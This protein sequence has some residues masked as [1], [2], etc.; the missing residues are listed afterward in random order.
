MADLWTEDIDGEKWLIN[1][2]LI[3]ANPG[4]RVK[5][6]NKR[7]VKKMASRRKR[8]MPA[9]LRRYWASRRKAKAN[10]HRRRRRVTMANPRRRR[11]AKR[12]F[13]MPGMLVNP[14]RRRSSRRRRRGFLMN[15][16]HRRH[17]RRNPQLLGFQLPPVSDI[18]FV[19]AGLVVPPIVSNYIMT[20]F[21]PSYTTSVPV[22]WA[23]NVASVVGP[24]L[25]VRKFVSQRAGNLMLLG[26]A[27]T[28][29]L[30]AIKT[31]MP[32][33]IPGLSGM[34]YQPFLGS[35]VRP[36]L[37]RGMGSYVQRSR[38]MAGLRGMGAGSG[39]T[40]PMSSSQV[41]SGTPERLLPSSRF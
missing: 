14:R 12:N 38:G 35:Y 34:G 4:R 17:A 23:V 30:Q 15:R 29:L 2:Q 9:G 11:R 3:I 25:L 39:Q 27:A 5:R 40:G 37:N 20:N 13:Q 10:P 6:S 18:A 16:R 41:Y 36:S 24:S 19:G 33:V 28:L 21:L 26:G 7:S 22:V 8:R 31:F 32:G 1:P